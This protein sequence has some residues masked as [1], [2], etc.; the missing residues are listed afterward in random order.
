MNK[1]TQITR[2][3]LVAA[4]GTLALTSCAGAGDDETAPESA[5]TQDQVQTDTP[6]F[7]YTGPRS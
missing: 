4:I 5:P 6:Q 2:L 7:R 1:L 3:T